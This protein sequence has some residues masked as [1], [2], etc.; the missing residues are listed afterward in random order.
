MVSVGDE[1][2]IWK[3]TVS[4]NI[5]KQNNQPQHEPTSLASSRPSKHRKL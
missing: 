2:N 1:I 5:R 3:D 4:H